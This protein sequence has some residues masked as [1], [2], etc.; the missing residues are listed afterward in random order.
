MRDDF[1]E[2]PQRHQ[3]LVVSNRVLWNVLLVGLLT[4]ALALVYQ[5]CISCVMAIAVLSLLLMNCVPGMP[6]VF[7]LSVG[8]LLAHAIDY[9][10]ATIRV[11]VPIGNLVHLPSY[12]ELKKSLDYVHVDP[13]PQP[14]VRQPTELQLFNEPW[15]TP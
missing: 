2:R 6:I 12:A 3:A 8:V 10:N 9:N 1:D 5:T 14:V 11:E 4:G 7:L 13:P 15:Q